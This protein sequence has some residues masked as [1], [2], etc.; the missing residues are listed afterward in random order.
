L[1]IHLLYFF[2]SYLIRLNF[3]GVFLENRLSSPPTKAARW[4]MAHQPMHQ[5]ARIV[6]AA[7]GG[8]KVSSAIAPN[9]NPHLSPSP[10]S[11]APQKP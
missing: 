6:F 4:R 10:R 2:N 11:P 3:P 5:P 9:P 1:E 8:Y 7:P